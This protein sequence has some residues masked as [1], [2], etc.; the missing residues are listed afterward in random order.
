MFDLSDQIFFTIIINGEFAKQVD[1]NTIKS[2]EYNFDLTLDITTSK[3]NV[4][5]STHIKTKK[6]SEKPCFMIG[7]YDTN[8]NNFIFSPLKDIFYKH[9]KQTNYFTEASSTIDKLFQ[10]R[11]LTIS[12]DYHY[13]IPYLFSVIYYNKLNLVKFVSE[14]YIGYCLIKLDYP[15][16]LKKIDKDLGMYRF[17]IQ[18]YNQNKNKLSR[19]QTKKILTIKS[20]KSKSN[21]SKSH[22]NININKFLS[23]MSKTRLIKI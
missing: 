7:I 16:S 23:R 18:V 9:L 13:I 22:K 5:K 10:N 17:S 4:I 20:N 15:L 12:E 6:V 21:K 2:L 19:T 3:T 11:N 8:N 14:G 1:S